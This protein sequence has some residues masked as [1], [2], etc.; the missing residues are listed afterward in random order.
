MHRIFIALLMYAGI[1]FS[2]TAFVN[3]NVYENRTVYINDQSN[4]N[5][6]GYG[7]LSVKVTGECT[8]K[9]C[10]G[11]FS[12][13]TYGLTIDSLLNLHYDTT[14][15]NWKINYLPYYLAAVP[16][17]QGFLTTTSNFNSIEY[18]PVVGTV[19]LHKERMNN[20]ITLLPLYEDGY[21]SEDGGP[22][23]SSWTNIFGNINE[24][25]YISRDGENTVKF[26]I[27]G[28][29]SYID[30][31]YT[32]RFASDSLGN[33]K[34]KIT[35]TPIIYSVPNVEKPSSHNIRLINKELY[36]PRTLKT[37]SIAI[38][39]CRGQEIINQTIQGNN[40]EIPSLSCGVYQYVIAGKGRNYTGSFIISR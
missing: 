36:L 28:S 19:T 14:D 15:E 34:F 6:K 27:L 23:G 1:L 12:G 3:L 24:I 30:L 16:N 25:F 10:Y 33:G 40:L 11:I 38:F 26:Q 35:G 32:I 31:T 22:I 21:W 29:S 5:I 13:I 7:F 9:P 17:Q 4:I 20:D 2:D 18:Y 8:S 37:G 39:N